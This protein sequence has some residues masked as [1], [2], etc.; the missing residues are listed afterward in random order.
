M[1]F[2]HHQSCECIKSEL[3]IFSTLPTQTSILDNHVVSYK[4]LSS[5]AEN[6]PIEFV[7]PGSS[8]EYIDLPHTLLYIQAEIV[9][10][11]GTK[12]GDTDKK[13]API[14]DFLNF[15]FSEVQ[16]YLNSKLISF[17]SHSHPYRSYFEKCGFE[18]E[19]DKWI[20]LVP[21]MMDL[22]NVMN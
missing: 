11:D 17:P 1:A 7:V 19:Q 15:I 6:A 20:L 13:V 12:F 9:K 16:V 10:P 2:L 4:P 21:A 5:L 8:D 22:Y 14:N 3:D 18:I